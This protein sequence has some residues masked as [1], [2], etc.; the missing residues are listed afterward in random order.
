MARAGGL[1]GGRES[2]AAISSNPLRRD[3]HDPDA[4]ASFIREFNRLWLEAR[5]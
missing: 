1:T 4:V 2:G 5:E 3:T